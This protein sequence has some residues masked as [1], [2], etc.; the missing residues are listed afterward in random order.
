[1]P[2]PPLAAIGLLIADAARRA[3]DYHRQAPVL[4]VLAILVVVLRAGTTHGTQLGRVAILVAP[5]AA[6]GF[7]LVSTPDLLEQR[8]FIGF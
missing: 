8:V 3:L 5:S 7:L 6:L 1:M 4:I 2:R